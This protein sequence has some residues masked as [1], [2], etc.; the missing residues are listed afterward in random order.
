MKSP[1]VLSLG[2]AMSIA[3]LSAASF[4]EDRPNTTLVQKSRSSAALSSTA[5]KAAKAQA[6]TPTS[7]TS[8]VKTG[9]RQGAPTPAPTAEAAYEGCH[10]KG[11]DA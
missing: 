1:T 10:G 11:G 5:T 4:A 6:A 9:A 2:L 3:F 7:A 8:T